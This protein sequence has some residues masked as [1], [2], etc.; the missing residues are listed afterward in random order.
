M[1]DQLTS[2]VVE[3]IEPPQNIVLSLD[4][5]TFR[6]LQSFLSNGQLDANT[7]LGYLASKGVFVPSTVITPSLTAPSHIAIATGSTA[8]HNNINANSFHLIKSP[9]NSNISGFGAPIGGYD[10]LHPDGA[11]EATEL[12]AEPLW[13]NLREN[14]K[15][16]VAATF[17]GAD[18]ATITLPGSNPPIVIQSSDIRTVDYTVPFGAFAGI[19]AQGFSLM[20]TN[21]NQNPTGAIIDLLDLGVAFY[22]NVQVADLENISGSSLFGGSSQD[23][24]IQA[25]AID[26][27]NDNRVNYD[28]VIVYDANTGI[29]INDVSPST[30]SAFLSLSSNIAPFFF[31]G[32]NNVAGAS[33]I[34]TELAED[35]STVHLIRTSANY[36]PRPA[37]NPDVLA[38]VDDINNAI[39]FWRPQPDFRIAQR[40]SPG[41]GDFSDIELETAYA[42]L[43]KT[44]IEYQTDVFLHAISQQPG[45]DLALGYLEEPDGS[46]HQYLLTDSRQPTDP[47][48]PNS[49]GEGQD[50]AKVA[51]Y[52]NLVLDAYK[53]VND[54]VQRVID[55]VGVDA[56]GLPNS[57]IIITS[58]H[59]FAPFH[60]AVSINN[61]LTNAGFDPN[62]VRA[63]SS[64]PA[65]NIY[66]NV[67]G[68]EPNGTVAT[69]E[70]RALQQQIIDTLQGLFDTNPNYGNGNVSLF[71]RVFSREVPNN[72][73]V[74]DII[75][76][77]GEFIGQDT[78]DVFALLSLGYNFDGFQ[79]NVARKD[80]TDPEAGDRP[81]LSVPTFYGAHGY[82]PNLPEMQATFI[83]AGPDF[84]PITLPNL[85]EIRSIDIAPTILDILDVEPADTVDGQSI[86]AQNQPFTLQLLHASDFEAGIEALDDA[87]RF[88][89]V[90]NGLKDDFENTLILS[91][92][93][94]YIPSPFLFAASD[95][96]LNATAVG[97][98]GLGRADITILNEI[99]IQASAFGNHEFDLGTREVQ[100]L[101]RPDG[102]YQGALFPYLSSNL[103]FSTDSNL[104][105]LV[106]AD[107]Q[108]AST[109]P[110][111][112][113]ASTVITVNG[114]KIGIVGAT[115]PILKSISSAG[116]VTVLP[117]NATDYD[118]LAAEI[119]LSVDALTATGINKIILLA[120]MQQLNIE[121]DELAPRLQDVDVIVA[122][123]SNTLLSDETDRL[124]TGD[125]SDGTY[126]I[127]K[128]DAEG[129][130]IAIVNT[131]GN[132]KYVGR[133]VIDFD[134]NGNIIPDSYD[135]EIGGAYAT[136]AAGVAAVGGTSDPEV[137]QITDTLR[138]VI[139]EQ[140]GNIFG[141]TDVFLRGDRTFV[142]T[143]ETN[144]GNLTADANLAAAKAVDSSTV[145]SI[146]NGGGI[147]SNIGVI[148]ASGGSTDP[149]DFQLLP[150]A[151]N[152]S[153]GKEEGDISQLDISNALRFNNGLSLLTL[154]AA[155]LQQTLEHGVR[156]TA[157]GATPGQ[158][159]Q[160]SGLAF[161]FDPDL[162]AAEDSNGN[163]V[164]DTGE[165]TN[166]NGILD[167]GERVRSLAIVNEAGQTIDVVV[168]NGQ[169]VGDPNRTFRTVTLGFL[170]SGGDSYPLLTFPNTNRV[171]LAPTS[172]NDFT[173]SGSEQDA[174][175]DYL[176]ANFSET[177]FSTADV[178]PELDTRIQNLNFREDTVL[179]GI[180]PPLP[181]VVTGTPGDDVFDTVI[182]DEKRFEGDNQILFAGSGDDYVDVTFAPGGN[183]ID[184][185]S[186]NDLIFAGTN[187][188]IIAGIG[189]DLIFVGTGGGNNL[190]TG[191][192][193]VDTFYLTQDDDLLP[194]NSNTISDYKASEGD[195]IGFIATS[196][197]F[198]A[199]GSDWDYRQNGADTIIEAF[200][201]DVAILKGIN[202]TNLT[203]SNFVFA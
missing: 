20:G 142:R 192:T 97:K 127:F 145:I 109:I 72:P 10:A 80:D 19:G 138:Q 191:G 62:Q 76:A 39:G 146:K 79:S 119:Q 176:A 83:A 164:L 201:Q 5:L 73:T 40:I 162:K 133:L 63:V 18:G 125:T 89:A 86:F 160:V 31:E 88:S 195:L 111:K 203:E 167:P 155:Q 32:S 3:E 107:A 92:G 14:G 189:D 147:R 112:I 57:N 157:P 170:A 96:A 48:D 66:I 143:E 7:G 65:V 54:A 46:T 101:I 159:P 93:D 16:V 123:G 163:G 105:G 49:I 28:R 135:P 183:R 120:H 4:G 177:P 124:R 64:G 37:D 136:D 134:A 144:F 102:A 98:A 60:T 61:I 122:G 113:A 30:G 156:A 91:S 171:D 115:T 199:L 198:E 165:D 34:L 84:N 190:I 187:N 110:N 85:T 6:F 51:R 154:S 132:Y 129:N 137:V 17:P 200:G 33:Y 38:D 25:A 15:T 23:Y 24:D 36:I 161:S 70:Y 1:T 94:N 9:F 118:A 140:D 45:A 41:L 197:T 67:A 71:D 178:G 158:F 77:S 151:A 87:P 180:T 8:A 55:Y 117:P 44:F 42:A 126:P 168:E 27:T 29:T 13:I 186:G 174:L 56:N 95:P 179:D 166:N 43:D 150:P 12:T 2:S 116:D 202:A 121:R 185:G 52:Q 21:F 78:G 11:H 141:K 90:I 103:D 69:S 114:E 108:E 99:G 193:G 181:K 175:A 149:N 194:A 59:G 100:G 148:S 139:N 47:S 82:D 74:E 35:L 68:R 196:L 169:L 128:T 22:G 26:T 184:T 172:G 182:P 75:T 131:D 130:P 153:A 50:L 106:T 58:D 173:T 152:P 81:L 188:R 104:S 53:T